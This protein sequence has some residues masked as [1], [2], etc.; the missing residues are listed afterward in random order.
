MSYEIPDVTAGNREIPA[1]KVLIAE[2]G[3]VG[4]DEPR[5]RKIVIDARKAWG[6]TTIELCA[7]TPGWALAGSMLRWDNGCYGIAYEVDGTSHSRRFKTFE[8]AR[9]LFSRLPE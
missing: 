1:G 7:W 5:A 4:P 9:E 2:Y 8:E 3:Q 6:G